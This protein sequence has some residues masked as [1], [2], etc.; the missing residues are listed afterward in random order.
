MQ[1]YSTLVAALLATVSSGAIILGNARYDS[2]Q[3]RDTAVWIDG[4]DPCAYT[5]MGHGNPCAFNGGRFQASNGFKYRIV[6]CDNGQPFQLQNENGS[7]NSDAK[8]DPKDDIVH[9]KNSQGTYTMSRTW[10][11]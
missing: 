3:H 1:L 9:C 6:N 10:V 8:H 11:F 4:Q 5:Y 2:D 7:L